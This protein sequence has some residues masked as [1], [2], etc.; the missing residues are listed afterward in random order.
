MNPYTLFYVFIDI[1]WEIWGVCVF[2]GKGP[3]STNEYRF[4]SLGQHTP[5]LKN[6]AADRRLLVLSILG[7]STPG[8]LI[9]SQAVCASNLQPLKGYSHTCGW[10]DDHRNDQR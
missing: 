3:M 1:H 4:E 8:P 9:C 10:A 5:S 6:S 2:I 7:G